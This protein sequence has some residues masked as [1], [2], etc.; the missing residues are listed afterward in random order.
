MIKKQSPSEHCS[1]VELVCNCSMWRILYTAK[2]CSNLPVFLLLLFFAVPALAQSRGYSL[3]TDRVEVSS[4]AHWRAWDFPGDMVEI[5]PAGAIRSRRVRGSYNAMLDAADFNHGIATNLRNQYAN[6]FELDDEL[7]ARG[8]VKAV[9]SNSSLAA[10][11]MD[12][13]GATFWEP[14]P[15]D[16]LRDW[17][18]EIDLGRLVSATKLV[19]RFADEGDPFLQFRVH[20]AGGLNPFGTSDRSG[21]LDYVLVGG[22]TQPNR[23]QRSFEFDLEPV[24]EYA[25]GWTGRMVQYVRIAVAAS[26]LDRAEV[27]SQA[28]Y[29]VLAA[30]DR[31]A[32]EYLWQVAG[33]ERLVSAE[34]YEELSAT[35]QGG[36]R[37]FRRERPR[38]AEMEVWTVGEN[39]SLGLIERGGSLHDVNPNASPHLAFDGD[40]RSEWSGV[41]YD[42]T[43]ETVE[44]GLLNIDL[45][46]HFRI[47][48]VRTVTRELGSIGRVLYGYLLRGS[49]GARAPDGSFIWE[50]LS[51]DDRLL[52]QNTRH[53]EDRFD[54]RALRFLEFRNLDIAR[55]TL[56]HLGHRVPSVV[57][58]IQVYADGYLPRLEMN[59]DLIDLGGA[60]NLTTIDWQADLPAGTSVEIRTR[61]GDDLREVNRYFKADGSEVANE[62][63]YGNLP[64]FFQGEI[65][66]E[67]LPGNGWSGWSQPYD[68]SGVRVLSPSPRRYM[69]VQA[70]LFSEDADTA[71]TLRSVQVHFTPP[72]AESIVGEITPKE[73]VPIGS[74]ADFELFVRPSFAVR[75]PGFDR[76][77]V[78]APSRATV[79]LQQVSLGS[80]SDFAGAGGDVYTRREDGLFANDSGQVLEVGGEETDSLSIEFPVVQQRGGAELLRL[81]F[82]TTVFQSGSTFAVEVGNTQTPDNWQRVDPGEGVGD[83]L[84]TGEGL[85]VLTPI[86]GRVIKALKRPGVL[87]PNG[88]GINDEVVFEFAILKI[89]TARSVGITLF[90]LS[91]RKMRRIEESRTLAN[92]LYRLLWDG[93]DEAGALVPPGLYLAQ[94]EVDSDSGDNNSVGQ[95]VGVAY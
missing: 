26:S 21:A 72:L 58:E 69:M 10:N 35:E 14:D 78:V 44:W 22:T 76:V 83:A 24:G 37:Y 45:G 91:G 79:I 65:Q 33:E 6:A 8:G 23:D 1:D 15:A 19:L 77:R 20:S 47:N 66:V 30:D 74:P 25:E 49:D 2:S 16:P 18:V 13:D 59:S 67:V 40:M 71:A 95:L 11:I 55:R 57:T 87:T 52:N 28:D 56:A 5:E 80:E 84:A 43:G 64:S 3:L 61:S 48:A 93:R 42:I 92:G 60:K 32:V 12:G 17:V 46:A 50:E 51:S 89:N 36:I 85:T 62:E 73:Q 94:I 75:D 41:V 4:S 63:E 9:G 90:D 34:R 31:G 81:S 38:L 29:Q 54:S 88:D 82:T 39:I 27:V 68:A 86:D 53:F 70:Q 7:L